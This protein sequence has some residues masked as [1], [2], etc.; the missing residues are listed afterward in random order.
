MAA[1]DTIVIGIREAVRAEDLIPTA[2]GA[3]PHQLI[4]VKA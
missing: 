2:A 3:V 4:I 1:A